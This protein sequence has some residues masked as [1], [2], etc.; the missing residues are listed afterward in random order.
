[1]RII[2]VDIY[3]GNNY[4]IRFYLC[5]LFVGKVKVFKV[6]ID[7]NFIYLMRKIF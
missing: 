1:M 6:L 4:K 3:V 2:Y 7:M 5:L